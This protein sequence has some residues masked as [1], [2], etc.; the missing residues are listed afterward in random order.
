VIEWFGFLPA[1]L[2]FEYLL[3]SLSFGDGEERILTLTAYGERYA[4]VVEDIRAIEEEAC[5]VFR[6]A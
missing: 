5:G 6:E 4:Q 3:V 2:V 1:G